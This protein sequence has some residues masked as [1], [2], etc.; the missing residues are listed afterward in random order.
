[1]QSSP[2]R[3]Q[4]SASRVVPLL[5]LFLSIT[6]SATAQNV[7]GSAQNF[8]VL[9]ASTVTNTGTTVIKGDL[10][11][12]PGTSIPGFP[13]GTV[14]GTNHGNDAASNLAQVN[15]NAAFTALNAPLGINLSGQNLGGLTLTPG[16]YTFSSSAQL[17][18]NL[19]LNYLGLSNASFV[20]QIGSTLTT[21]SNS[22]VTVQNAGPGAGLYWAV[23][24]SAT[25]GT[26]T[27]FSGNVLAK[28][29]ITLTTD[30]RI[31]CGRA[32][33]LTGA[34]T[35]DQNIVSNNCANGGDFGT[36]RNDFGSLGFSG[37]TVVPEPST[38]VLLVA[39]ACVLLLVP[40][41]ARRKA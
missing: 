19:T 8:G 37:A 18:G 40:R 7:L 22:S 20:F 16:V 38:L 10:G 30:A 31:I 1:M 3:T 4:C 25:L 35:L 28:T 24:S 11:V 26:G 34:V 33:A 41:S 9:G 27:N 32:I 2:L 23:G 21:A 17:T 15:A 6:S 5:I 29:S 12:S 14:I 13:P 39:G 36:G